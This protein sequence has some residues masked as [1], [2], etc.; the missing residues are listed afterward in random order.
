MWAIEWNGGALEVKGSLPK[1]LTEWHPDPGLS[2]S[3]AVVGPGVELGGTVVGLLPPQV[4]GPEI[5]LALV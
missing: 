5:N 4:L 3:G 1:I 2:L